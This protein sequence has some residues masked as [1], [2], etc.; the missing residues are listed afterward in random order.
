MKK[1]AFPLACALS[2][3][4]SRAANIGFVSFHNTDLPNANAAGAGQGFTAAPD[5]G[6][7]DLLRNAG[8]TVTRFLTINDINASPT[9]ASILNGFDLIIISRSVDSSHYG[10]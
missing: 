4:T 8:H 1:L 3:V 6:Y 10:S 2:A 9:A 5:I 7:T